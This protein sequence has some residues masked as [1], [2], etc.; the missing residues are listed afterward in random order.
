MPT[1]L[2]VSWATVLKRAGFW[3]MIEFHEL[4]S[5]LCLPELERRGVKIDF[6]F[7]DGNHT[8][9][10]VLVDLFLIDKLLNVNGIIVLDDA[11]YASVKKVCRYALTNLPYVVSG[12]APSR[13]WHPA[14]FRLISKTSLRS[15]TS[16]PITKG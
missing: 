7:I 12:P 16:P 10:Y 9:D 11:N 8:F 5:Y 4:P 1:Y 15:M 6:A 14:L 2:A 13:T 3:D